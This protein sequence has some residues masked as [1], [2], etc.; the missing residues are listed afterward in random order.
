MLSCFVFPTALLRMLPS[1]AIPSGHASHPMGPSPVSSLGGGG[2]AHSPE[3]PQLCVP[4]ELST[5]YR[6]LQYQ[7]SRWLHLSVPPFLIL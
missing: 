2:F 5:P 3:P 4:E 6:V 1:F 7:L